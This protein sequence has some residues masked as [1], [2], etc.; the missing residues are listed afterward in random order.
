MLALLVLYIL[1]TPVNVVGGLFKR[2][3]PHGNGTLCRFPEE[4]VDLEV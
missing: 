4:L 1:G 2:K 3:K